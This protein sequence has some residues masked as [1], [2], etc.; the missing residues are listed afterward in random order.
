MI[1]ES[2]IRTNWLNSFLIYSV[3]QYAASV[4]RGV[5]AFIAKNY[6]DFNIATAWQPLALKVCT[7]LLI[8]SVFAF[9]TYHCAYKKEGT[10]WLLFQ[11]I[12]G[13][14]MTIILIISAPVSLIRDRTIYALGVCPPDFVIIWVMEV[15]SMLVI[16][17]YIIQCYELY[18]L[19]KKKQALAIS[20]GELHNA[21]KPEHA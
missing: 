16:L 14:I 12:M 9:I 6:A 11:V 20:Q 1:N 19:N 3:F 17:Q 13:T 5:N 21:L 4:I 7:L 18:A 2:C 10:R 8:H 15:I